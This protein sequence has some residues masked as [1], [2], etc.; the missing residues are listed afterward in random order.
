M[1]DKNK[2]DLKELDRFLKICR[3]NG[4]LDI[5]FNGIKAKLDENHAKTNKKRKKHAENDPN[6]I[7]TDELTPEQLMFY[8]VGQPPQ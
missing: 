7:E 1:A 8:A 6:N 3:K 2:L 4:V 5:D